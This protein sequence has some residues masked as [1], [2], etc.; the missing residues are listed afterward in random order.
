[1]PTELADQ[2]MD[3]SYSEG[4]ESEEM[5]ENVPLKISF[6]DVEDDQPDQ[7]S[8]NTSYEEA[9]IFSPSSYTTMS[10]P[11]ASLAMESADHPAP[12]LHVLVRLLLIRSGDCRVGRLERT[13][14][15][16]KRACEREKG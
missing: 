10:D 2:A 3:P 7:P 16:L 8:F 14:Q 12:R 5:E 11:P 9:H 4:G 15:Q 1:M 6:D 13:E